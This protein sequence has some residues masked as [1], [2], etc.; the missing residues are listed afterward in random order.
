MK[1][2][3]IIQDAW[4]FTQNNKG[5]IRWYGFLPALFSIVVSTLYFTYQFYAYKSSKLFE[6]WDRSFL[7]E[8]FDYTYDFLQKYA[9]YAWLII[10]VLLILALLNLFLPA[11]CEGAMIQIIARRYNGQQVKDSEGIRYG[12]LSFL[13]LFEYQLLRRSLSIVSIV[14]TASIFL[15]TWG[16]DALGL[17]TSVFGFITIVALIMNL[18][19]TYVEFYIVIDSEDVFQAIIKSCSLVVSQWQMTFLIGVLMMIIGVR[20]IF[21]LLTVLIVPILVILPA[22]YLA[23]ITFANI[24]LIIGIVVAL[25]VVFFAAYFSAILQLF[26]SSVW[27]MTFLELS[28]AHELAAREKAEADAN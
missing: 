2:R 25:I 27:V 13:R 8:I 22:S 24:G 12:L 28:N 9:E 17:I 3:Q 1:Y 21:Q 19:F 4:D 20:V 6:D 15:R 5:L 14:A 18:L 23:T 7:L 26:A 11:I 16:L 10:L